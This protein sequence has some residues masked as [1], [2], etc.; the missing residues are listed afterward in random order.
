MDPSS[1][2]AEDGYVWEAPYPGAGPET[3]AWEVTPASVGQLAENAFD[4][5]HAESNVLGNDY[6]YPDYARKPRTSALAQIP[7]ASRLV[8]MPQLQQRNMQG[9][10]V[11]QTPRG[12]MLWVGSPQKFLPPDG[13]YPGGSTG[14]PLDGYLAY[15]TGWAN[16]GPFHGELAPIQEAGISDKAVP[17]ALRFRNGGNKL[18]PNNKLMMP[19]LSIMD[20]GQESEPFDDWDLGNSQADLD[21]TYDPNLWENPRQPLSKYN[22]GKAS[23]IMGEDCHDGT[24]QGGMHDNGLQLYDNKPW[25]RGSI[26]PNS[27]KSVHAEYKTRANQQ[28]LHYVST[29]AS[30]AQINAMFGD[31]NKYHG[32]NNRHLHK[33]A[34]HTP[35]D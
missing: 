13:D 16:D 18:M 17:M 24:H 12:P 22:M 27:D 9:A 34:K 19:V 21:K 28:A 8:S 35:K 32:A 15:E 1:W 11:V 23:C 2:L 29:G 7:L 30:N 10:R 25:S 33:V 6:Q 14:I 20:P 5:S 26:D 4:P 31:M 3:P